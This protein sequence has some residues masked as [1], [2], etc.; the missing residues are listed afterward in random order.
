MNRLGFA[1]QKC[2][3]MVLHYPY[4]HKGGTK[5]SIEKKENKGAKRDLLVLSIVLFILT[6]I[7]SLGVY[8][9]S[10]ELIKHEKPP[11]LLVG[12]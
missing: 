2:H 7:S 6:L 12:K 11:I 10:S 8:T 1:P 5:M 3:Y 4:T 9:S